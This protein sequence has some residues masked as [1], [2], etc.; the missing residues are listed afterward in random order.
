MSINL[1]DEVDQRTNLAFTNQ[2]EMLTFYLS[3]H[4]QYGINVFKIIEV[5]ETPKQVTQVAKLHPAIVGSINFRD[6]M[7]TVLDLSA[8][9]GLDAVAFRQEVSYIIICEYSNTVQGFLI[10]Q[11]NRLLQK[12]WK[13]IK[14]PGYGVLDQGFL[15]AITYDE[16]E[17]AIQIL[18]IERILG[19]VLGI[20]LEVSQEIVKQ[21]TGI[22]FSQA[23]VLIVDDS[24][25]ALKMLGN[26]LDKLKIPFVEQS[27][28]EDALNYL[29][30][31][32]D[33]EGRT[34]VN[35]IISDI[36]MPG[37][38]GFT[39][40][41]TVKAH[42]ELQ[43]I[44]LI[45]HSSMSNKANRD[46]AIKVGADDFVAKFKPDEIARAIMEHLGVMLPG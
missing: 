17:H 10:S 19:E 4:Q 7:V 46:K 18:D 36:E 28:A 3:D 25:A 39:L 8:A 9:M 26:T 15:T 45:L 21:G 12:S 34:P 14:R 1:M 5:I 11:P 38:D 41:R 13:E 22:D 42:P 40:T 24:R 35:M 33:A 43:S 29:H 2:M 16:E 20:S 31:N 32:L 6:T 27:C 37:M 23:L 30:K 44:P